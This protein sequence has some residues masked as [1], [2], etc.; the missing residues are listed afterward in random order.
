MMPHDANLIE[1]MISAKVRTLLTNAMGEIT[2]LIFLSETK[3]EKI[4]P[5]TDHSNVR[6]RRWSLMVQAIVTVILALV[7]LGAASNSVMAEKVKLGSTEAK[8]TMSSCKGT[9]GVTFPKTGPNSTFGCMNS[10]GSGIVCGGVKKSDK[11]T[12]D[13]FMQT[14]PRLPTRGEVRNAEMAAKASQA[15]QQSTEPAV[16]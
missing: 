16:N 15:P 10:D 13:I 11:T 6:N 2:H 7:G 12:C 4:M 1:T 9:G 3:G 5:I 14:P 8:N